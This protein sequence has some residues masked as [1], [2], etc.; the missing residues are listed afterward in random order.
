[1]KNFNIKLIRFIH[2]LLLIYVIIC[3]CLFKSQKNFVITLLF[4]ILFRWMTNDHSCLLTKIENK[5]SGGNGGFIYR[6]VNPIYKLNES[7]FQKSLYF[8]TYSWVMILILSKYNKENCLNH[9]EIN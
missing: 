7:Q 5:I 4:F 3:P 6:L 2:F 1:M 8:I 9:L